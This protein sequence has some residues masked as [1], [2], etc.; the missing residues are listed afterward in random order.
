MRI[1]SLHPSLLDTKGLVA[2]WRET[3]LA[4]K[5]L[6]GNTKGYT[7]HPQLQRFKET[8]NPIGAI[9][10][11]LSEVQKEA[12]K[13][14]YNFDKTKI[15]WNF[16]PMEISVTDKQIRYEFQ[17]LL[18]KLKIRDFDKFEKLHTITKIKTHPMFY[19][20]EGDIEKWEIV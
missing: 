13:R 9:N 20:I 3:L 16:S 15:D 6:E 7:Q 18:N 1:W 17:H 11:Y 2:L 19:E 4:K 10:F 8:D 5:V 14:G 12:E